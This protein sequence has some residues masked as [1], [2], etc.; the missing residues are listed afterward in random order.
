MKFPDTERVEYP[1][2]PL[3]EVIC[4]LR[5]PRQFAIEES[6]PVELQKLLAN[7]FPL[8]DTSL[9]FAVGVGEADEPPRA[10]RRT[11]Y[12]FSS[13][14]RDLTITLASD[15]V[16][17]TSRQYRNW[18][19]FAE[20]IK[21]AW[22]AVFR[23]YHITLITRIGLR[24]RNIIA[25]RELGLGEVPWSKLVKPELIGFLGSDLDG[26]ALAVEA[27][28]SHLFNIRKGRLALHSSLVH[29]NDGTDTA[30]LIDSDFFSEDQLD[31][32]QNVYFDILNEYNLE[33][34]RL[35]RWAIKDKLSERL[36]SPADVH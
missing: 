22:E 5:F 4:Q 2:N 25:R 14:E 36:S 17:V 9:N 13:R 28:T 30:L 23:V 26:A 16:A 18:A 10:I 6:L 35:F 24:Y 32:E 29:S 21:K 11:E 27:S 7:E 8:A 3:A 19:A 31:G 12:N 34:G 15:F 20:T 1:R 33:A